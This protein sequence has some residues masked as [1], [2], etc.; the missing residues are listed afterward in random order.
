MEYLPQGGFNSRV[1]VVV[2]RAGL[3]LW[4]SSLRA[5]NLG[6]RRNADAE[7]TLLD[8]RPEEADVGVDEVPL[9]HPGDSARRV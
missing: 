6:V 9:G 7:Q 3:S 8:L 2:R 5:A 4:S 1:R